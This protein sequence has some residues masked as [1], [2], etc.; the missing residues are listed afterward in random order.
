MISSYVDAFVDAT[1]QAYAAL[2]PIFSPVSSQVYKPVQALADFC[3]LSEM[4][5]ALFLCMQVA[6][7]LSFGLSQLK[8]PT[9]RKWY[10]TTFGLLLGFYLLGLAYFVVIAQ[11]VCAY[12][13][14]VVMPTR[15]SAM[16]LGIALVGLIMVLRNL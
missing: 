1:L 8:Q 13:A 2:A 11:I 15:R 9:V 16:F 4:T 10:S 12:V 7:V 14:M 3:D 5:V 6:G